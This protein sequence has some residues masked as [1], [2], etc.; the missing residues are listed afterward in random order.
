MRGLGWNRGCGE[1]KEGKT[2]GKP[3]DLRSEPTPTGNNG[4]LGSGLQAMCDW[5]L[6]F[7][8]ENGEIR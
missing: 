3:D 8:D 4:E 2:V 1:E 6:P 5:R 7:D